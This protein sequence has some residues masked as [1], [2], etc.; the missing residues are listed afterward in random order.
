MDCDYVR[1]S[2]PWEKSDG[3]VYLLRELAPLRPDTVTALLPLLA[4]IADLRDFKHHFHLLETIWKQLPT[5]AK[6]VG[7]KAFKKSIELFFPAMHYSLVSTNQLARAAAQDCVVALGKVR[8]CCDG[9]SAFV[10]GREKDGERDPVALLRALRMFPL[11]SPLIP[12]PPTPALLGT[13]SLR[14]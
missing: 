10:G 5:I 1:P 7:K 12:Y 2:E 9:E 14:S 11:A 13:F 8:H 3:C 4:E 6:G